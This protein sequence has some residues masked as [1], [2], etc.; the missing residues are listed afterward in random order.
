[1][2]KRTRKHGK[3]NRKRKATSKSQVIRKILTSAV[4]GAAPHPRLKLP[5]AFRAIG[6]DEQKIARCF[7]KHIKQMQS[8][9]VP[10]A[11][12]KLLLDWLKEAI[13]VLYPL[14]RRGDAPEQ[15]QTIE[16]V[17][18]VPRPDRTS[19]AVPAAEPSQC[20]ATPA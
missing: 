12:R 19:D 6:L 16:L 10:R 7:A 3:Q 8:K 1:M 4:R 18:F 9:K 20:Q 13:R 5:D 2:K 15:P 14:A 17:H 11:P